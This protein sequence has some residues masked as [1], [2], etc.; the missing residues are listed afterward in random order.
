M[1]NDEEILN[2]KTRFITLLRKIE[3][4]NC[5]IEGLIAKLERSDFFTAPASTQYHCGFKGGL[6][7][8]SLNVYDQLVKL[9][10][11]EYPDNLIELG[12][13]QV[14][15]NSK[16]A[17]DNDSV[18][19]TAL[20]HDISKMN[21]Y[22]VADRNVK[23]EHGDWTKVP[24]IKVRE[25]KD[26]FIYGS[27]EQNSLYIIST[28]IPLKIEEE[29]AVLNHMGGKGYDSTQADLTPIYNKYSLALLLHVADM[30]ATFMD[31]NI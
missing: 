18:L 5:D 31:E 7:Q 12:K 25:V 9:I 16:K 4:P 22:E 2:N 23:D 30:L 13:E 6:C 8:H 29:V 26:R 28:Y 15:D 20:L 14:I 27:H 19:I 10:E 11:I 21:F 24:Y 3:R 1:L 17:P